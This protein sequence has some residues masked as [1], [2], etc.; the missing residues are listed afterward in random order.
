MC[1][2]RRNENFRYLQSNLVGSLVP[3]KTRNLRV[4]VG[5]TAYGVCLLLATCVIISQVAIYWNLFLGYLLDLL[6]SVSVDGQWICQSAASDDWL[7]SPF[8]TIIHLY[9]YIH[10]SI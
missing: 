2:K 1:K 9:I 4:Y 5:V 3:G 10:I 7:P 8:A 6:G